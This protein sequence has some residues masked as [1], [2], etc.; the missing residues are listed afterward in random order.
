MSKNY[1]AVLLQPDCPKEF[2]ES[3]SD[4]ILYAKGLPYLLSET[5]L[6]TGGY[7]ATLLAVGKDSKKWDIQIPV[8]YILMIGKV[9]DSKTEFGFV[10]S[11]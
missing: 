6:D 7:F 10:P 1:H 3:V 11:K 9:S 8:S 5:A 4:Y 2:L